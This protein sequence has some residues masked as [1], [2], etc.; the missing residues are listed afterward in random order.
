MVD[1]MNAQQLRDA[2]AQRLNKACDAVGIRRRG[3]AVDLQKALNH[4]GVHNSTTAIGKWLK[5]EATP[6][7]VNLKL[8]AELLETRE[9]WLEYG[10]QQLTEEA[11]H[12]QLHAPAIPMVGPVTPDHEGRLEHFS[13][14]PGT[15]TATTLRFSSADQKA[16]A[17]QINGSHLAP[18][19]QHH[20]YLIIEPSRQY[21]AGDEVLI[22]TQNEGCLIR[23][24]IALRAGQYRFDSINHDTSPLY[25]PEAS[26]LR[27]HAM[28]AILKYA[29]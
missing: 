28:S 19:L 21:V 17:L 6:N 5:G 1:H 12:Y 14:T 22:Y 10:R 4:L 9:E 29:H 18:R 24:F 23:E 20:E 27:M 13:Y 11:G 16:Y 25:L 7:K 3:R 8:L 26:V 15:A 2:F